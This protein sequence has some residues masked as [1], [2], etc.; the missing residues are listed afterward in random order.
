MN[1]LTILKFI[2]VLAVVA[3]L[4]GCGKA[5][6]AQ[7]EVSATQSVVSPLG[8]FNSPVCF[9]NKLATM[10]IGQDIY[11]IAGM[12]FKADGQGISTFALYTDQG[13]ND[14]L[15]AGTSNFTYENTQTFGA[16]KVLQIDQVNN[17][18]DPSSNFRYWLLVTV[19]QAGYTIDM[20]D[21]NGIAGPFM[22]E[23]SEADAIAFTN[24]V[25]DR[26]VFFQRQ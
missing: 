10:G 25:A 13:C 8:Q 17:P 7:G 2:C 6:Q 18:E 26:G 4:V 20:D 22:S 3:S 5:N 9:K 12:E 15:G 1:T 21:T 19:T 11:T 14:L 16:V 24:Q 23:P